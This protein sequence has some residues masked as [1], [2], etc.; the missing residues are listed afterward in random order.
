MSVRMVD[1]DFAG[2]ATREG[3]HA[4]LAERMDFPP[5]YGGNLDALWDM[6]T[7]CG[8]TAVFLWDTGEL[9]D[10]LGAYGKRVVETFEEA[11]KE[12]DRLW[13]FFPLPREDPD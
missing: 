10:A 9:E 12:N 13:V 1:L 11:A 2:I 8:D 3:L 5:Y 6:L 4:Y 7:T